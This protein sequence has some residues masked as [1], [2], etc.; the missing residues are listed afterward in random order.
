MTYKIV[1]QALTVAAAA[2]I[3][4]A[5]QAATIITMPV[6]QAIFE[7]SSYNGKF[8]L[9]STLTGVD[10]QRYRV[11]S[12]TLTAFGYSSPVYDQITSTETLKSLGSYT[13]V[14]YF[15]Y[16]SMCDNKG[17]CRQYVYPV[18]G[19]GMAYA[20][21][22]EI[23]NRDTLIDSMLLASGSASLNSSVSQQPVTT[24]GNVYK[25]TIDTGMM[26]YS[27]YDRSI[28]EGAFGDMEGAMVLTND[29]LRDLNA[30]SS[31]GYSVSAPIGRF[32][33]NQVS[34]ALDL[35]AIPAV[36]EPA[37]WMM[38]V[39]GFCITGSALRG[40]RRRRTAA[41]AGIA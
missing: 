34:L 9:S 27:N 12:A 19:I 37:T 31:I 4:V 23:A 41:I 13:Y 22:T 11:S 17:N 2:T 35:E 26:R 39:A 32:T 40:Q 20:S 18:Q 36:P 1:A 5:A 15:E 3:S 30:S 21:T 7:G 16:R 10:G 6:G 33:L 8:D 28:Y 29:Q 25:G 14:S 24:S 38:M